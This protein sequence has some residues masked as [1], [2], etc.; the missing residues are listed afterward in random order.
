MLIFFFFFTK[1]YNTYEQVY[2]KGTNEE[3]EQV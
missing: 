1:G 3:N 2:L